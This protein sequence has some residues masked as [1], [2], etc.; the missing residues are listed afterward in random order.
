MHVY[1]NESKPIFISSKFLQQAWPKDL[2]FPIDYS[3]QNDVSSMVDEESMDI[4]RSKRN[5]LTFAPKNS[6]RSIKWMCW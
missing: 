4:N 6:H 3:N 2:N 5:C 1:V